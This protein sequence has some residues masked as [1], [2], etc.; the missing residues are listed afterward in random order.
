MELQII[1][2][3]VAC[4][5]IDKNLVKVTK[6]SSKVFFLET[7]E[8]G[9][10]FTNDVLDALKRQMKCCDVEWYAER[11]N[12]IMITCT[13]D[14]VVADIRDSYTYANKVKFGFVKQYVTVAK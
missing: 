9:T 12:I 1:K 7:I 13:K 11:K 8:E 2:E 14:N 6:D 4:C 10:T 3:F 5:L